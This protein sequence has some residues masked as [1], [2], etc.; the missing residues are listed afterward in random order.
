MV[1]L[2]ALL[3]DVDGTIAETEEVHRG[4]FNLA[5]AEAGLDWS[6]DRAIYGRLLAVAGG[7]ERLAHFVAAY[8]PALPEAA[9]LSTLI[10]ALHRAKTAHYGALVAAGHAEWRPGVERLLRAARAAGIRL[11]IATTTSAANLPPLLGDRLTWFEVIAT[12]EQASAKKPDPAVYLWALE[13]LG[14]EP[15]RCMAIEDSANGVR[16]ARA[17]GIPVVVTESAYSAG[18]DFTGALAV[19]SDLGEPGR[20]FTPRHGDVQNRAYVDLDMLRAWHAR[21]ARR[22]S[23]P[24]ALD[25]RSV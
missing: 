24:D 4:A 2:A 16:A 23:S 20:P 8:R 5:F 1:G 3:F 11:A 13:R 18:E 17:A 12:A 22:S 6:W 14:L 19:L 9:D 15:S 7:R 21:A 25:P 10:A